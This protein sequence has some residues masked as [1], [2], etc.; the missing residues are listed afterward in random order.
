M[1]LFPDLDAKTC[2]KQTHYDFDCNKKHVN[3]AA[4]F[5]VGGW[6]TESGQAKVES[7]HEQHYDESSKKTD[8]NRVFGLHKIFSCIKLISG[9]FLITFAVDL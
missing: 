5:S 2:N 8:H 4:E 1:I 6:P 3:A 9:F 7:K